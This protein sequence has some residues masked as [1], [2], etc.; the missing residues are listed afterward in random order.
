MTG[1]LIDELRSLLRMLKQEGQVTR[2]AVARIEM[3]LTKEEQ[4]RM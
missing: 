1:Q 2:A 4:W 3:V